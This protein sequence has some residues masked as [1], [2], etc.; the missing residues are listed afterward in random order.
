MSDG[1]PLQT[2]VVALKDE[3][4]FIK[5]PAFCGN[6]NPQVV[7]RFTFATQDTFAVSLR[8]LGV[9]VRID[10]DMLVFGCQP[11]QSPSPPVGAALIASPLQSQLNN[12]HS[13]FNPQ[14]AQRPLLP[15]A[16]TGLSSEAV[17]A[18]QLGRD[19]LA[20]DRR[21]ETEIVP[22]VRRR[23]VTEWLDG[24]R[25]VAALGKLPGL[26]VLAQ[27]GE[28][29]PVLLSGPP[30][31]VAI[32]ADYIRAID[33]CPLQLAFEASILTRNRSSGRTIAGGIQVHGGGLS[34]SSFSIGSAPPSISGFAASIPGLRAFLDAT[35]A[36]GR[37]DQSAVLRGRVVQGGELVLNDGR[38]VA[39]RA[40]TQT[41]AVATT[42]NV[43]YRAV[44]HNITLK[45]RVVGRDYVV[46]ELQ[47]QL[48]GVDSQTDLGPSF[49]ARTTK[50]V[51]RVQP[52][53][54]EIV[55]LSGLDS[56]VHSR[57]RGILSV[58]KVHST[59]QVGAFLVFAVAVEPCSGEGGERP[60][61]T[62]PEY[63]GPRPAFSPLPSSMIAAPAEGAAG[64]RRKK[65]P[66]QRSGVFSSGSPPPS[67]SP[68]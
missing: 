53:R 13:L 16:S 57:A 41:T 39:I 28:P 35:A 18:A 9:L 5:P 46:V 22:D 24:S 50:T 60:Q 66:S 43:E 32:A 33:V 49:A 10:G 48:S 23:T 17:P 40:G 65:N 8:M 30:A 29:G 45:P 25:I 59:T 15:S 62:E 12:L 37:L 20:D 27:D 38:E 44:G 6:Y 68:W 58:D 42:A 26:S 61:P 4:H 47:H 14:A 54:P 19:G 67:R 21:L 64:V 1:T 51:M 36:E 11:A 3:V 56:D 52:G 7:G 31:I 63:G 55:S 34:G 2:L